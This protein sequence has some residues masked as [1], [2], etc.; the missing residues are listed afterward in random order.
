MGK[1]VLDSPIFLMLCSVWRLKKKSFSIFY[2]GSSR[3][4][5][6][7]SSISKIYVYSVPVIGYRIHSPLVWVYVSVCVF[8]CIQVWYIMYNIFLHQIHNRKYYSRC[9]YN[10]QRFHDQTSNLGPWIWSKPHL[11]RCC[12]WLRVCGFW[13]LWF[14]QF[15]PRKHRATILGS[16]RLRWPKKMIHIHSAQVAG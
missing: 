16:H 3:A 15:F 10:N 4:F 8:V 12:L 13:I 11:W 7:T 5:T 2:Q 14:H 6:S 1:C 9:L